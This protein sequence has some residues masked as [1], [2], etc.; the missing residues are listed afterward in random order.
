MLR[1]GPGT[2]SL[3]NVHSSDQIYRRARSK[4]RR[5]DAIPWSQPDCTPFAAIHQPQTVRTTGGCGTVARPTTA[6]YA[7]V[8]ITSN[9]PKQV[10]ADGFRAFPKQAMPH[11]GSQ[12][13]SSRRLQLPKTPFCSSPPSPLPGGFTAPTTWKAPVG[14]T[15]AGSISLLP[16]PPIHQQFPPPLPSFRLLVRPRTQ[17]IPDA[18]YVRLASSASSLTHSPS[19][20]LNVTY[21]E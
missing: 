17:L 13:N 14:Q 21:V 8:C 11:L 3:C 18:G 19:P 1:M 4:R 15:D 2:I 7:Y 9:G 16:L 5:R 10:V 20:S 12:P 6:Q